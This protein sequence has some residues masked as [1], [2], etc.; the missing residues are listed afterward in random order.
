MYATRQ[1][2]AIATVIDPWFKLALFDGDNTDHALQATKCGVDIL[3]SLAFKPPLFRNVP[4]RYQ[5]IRLDASMIE[6]HLEIVRIRLK[7]LLFITNNSS[8]AAHY[9]YRLP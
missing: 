1:Q 2:K 6:Y 7:N 4:T 8:G 9:G 3:T 5:S